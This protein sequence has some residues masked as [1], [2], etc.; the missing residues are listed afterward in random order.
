MSRLK[1]PVSDKQAREI[2]ALG[3]KHAKTA[4][5][6]PERV[7]CPDD[8]I[9]R[10]MA[11]RDKHLRPSE[12]PVSHVATCSPYFREYSR[13]RRNAKMLRAFQVGAGS[14]LLILAAVPILSLMRENRQLLTEI[15]IIRSEGVQYQR[16]LEDLRQ[17]FPSQTVRPNEDPEKASNA[18]I[19]AS[20]VLKPGRLRSGATADETQRLKVT[21]R[22]S[23][24]LFLVEVERDG[25]TNYD[26]SLQNADG[27][28]LQSVKEL[29]RLLK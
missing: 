21:V 11:Y 23:L 18:V 17:R 10:A 13:Y 19:T 22:P 29:S 7:N 12:L 28:E 14:L 26:V 9:L 15:E 24:I 5:P 6:N 27:R 20:I 2:V 25:Y 3:K 4:F 16:Q 1:H 8:S